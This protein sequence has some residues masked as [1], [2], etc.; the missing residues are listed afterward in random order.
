M[1]YFDTKLI[2]DKKTSNITRIISIPP[3]KDFCKIILINLNNLE[4]FK[5]DLNINNINR[6]V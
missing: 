6:N 2:M 5:I 3:F 4:V 1:P